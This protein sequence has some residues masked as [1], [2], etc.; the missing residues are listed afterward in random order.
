MCVKAVI[1]VAVMHKSVKFLH[2]VL[3]VAASHTLVET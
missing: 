1:V 3:I 2:S